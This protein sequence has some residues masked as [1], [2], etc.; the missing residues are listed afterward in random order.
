MDGVGIQNTDHIKLLGIHFTTD[1]KWQKEV[2][3]IYTKAARN[4]SAVIMLTKTGLSKQDILEVY[5]AKIRP[6]MEYAC[7]V[8]HPGLTT[9]QSD[10]LESIQK[11]VLKIV[12]KDANYE[13]ALNLANLPKLS[14]R[15]EHMCKK[16]FEQM[17]D[18]NHRLNKFLPP[19]KE[20]THG[21]R[22]VNTYETIR[23][24][25]TRY[26]HTFVP[27]CLEGASIYRHIR[28]SILYGKGDQLPLFLSAFGI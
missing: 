9:E 26:K 11:R 23:C 4:I 14:E 10:S 21:L 13:E 27:Y 7:Q 1:L 16:L 18:K 2:D 25:T 3:E 15:R 19:K 20:N 28:T 22:I 6:I 24:K 5:C 12:Y 8:W 17:K